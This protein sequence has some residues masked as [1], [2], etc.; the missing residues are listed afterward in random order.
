MNNSIYSDRIYSYQTVY[1]NFHSGENFTFSANMLTTNDL[2]L[3][4]GRYI[5]AHIYKPDSQN[6]FS[7]NEN[8]L[9]GKL[10]FDINK[11]D[12]QYV[13][14]NITFDSDYNCIYVVLISKGLNGTT[15]FD[16]VGLCKDAFYVANHQLITTLDSHNQTSYN[17]ELISEYCDEEITNT[18]QRPTNMSYESQVIQNADENSSTEFYIS[19]LVG[20]SYPNDQKHKYSCIYTYDRV[21]DLLTDN[22][23]KVG[24][25]FMI[26]YNIFNK[27]SLVIN[28]FN[29]NN[30]FC[31]RYITDEYGKLV[32]VSPIY[33]Y[34]STN[35]SLN[36][37]YLLSY[38]G[39]LLSNISAISENDGDDFVTFNN[40]E[41]SV[42]ALVDYEYNQWGD[43]KSI[44]CRDSSRNHYEY[45]YD[46]KRNLTKIKNPDNTELNFTYDRNNNLTL[47]SDN[48]RRSSINYNENHIETKYLYFDNNQRYA[49]CDLMNG[50][51]ITYQNGITKEYSIDDPSNINYSYGINENGESEEIINN[52][53]YTY[54]SLLDTNNSNKIINKYKFYDSENDL[55]VK[56]NISNTYDDFGRITKREY[57]YR[58]NSTPKFYIEYKYVNSESE[59]N[60]EDI[61]ANAVKPYN[62]LTELQIQDDSI[63]ESDLVEEVVYYA[64]RFTKL[65]SYKYSYDKNDN[66][67]LALETDYRHNDN[68][69]VISKTSYSY[70]DDNSLYSETDLLNYTT[71]KYYYDKYGN[72]IRK[73]ISPLI[74]L[75]SNESTLEELSYNNS[76]DNI[77]ELTSFELINN[78]DY[79]D[80]SIE[81][82]NN[83]GRGNVT[84]Y[85]NAAYQYSIN[86]SL[87]GFKANRSSNGIKIQNNIDGKP[88][89]KTDSNHNTY[90]YYWQDGHISAMTMNRSV[91]TIL[92]DNDKNPCGFAHSQEDGTTE[93]YFYILDGSNK[94]MGIMDSNLNI[95]TS[96]SYDA[97]GK[98]NTNF[99]TEIG[100]SVNALNPLVYNGYLYDYDMNLYFINGRYYSPKFY[101]YLT[102]DESIYKNCELPLSFNPYIYN[103]NN[104]VNS[105]NT[106]KVEQIILQ[107]S[108][109]YYKQKMFD[110]KPI[111]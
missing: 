56:A 95:I 63:I 71:Y 21:N 68:G 100:N 42:K 80:N 92:Y 73:T 70:N 44:S 2:P 109:E 104:P 54:K 30:S 20:N 79:E 14:N 28:A 31:R 12:W 93:V 35:N 40:E 74:S 38:T 77:G 98:L 9:L 46:N 10:H 105:S 64:D 36:N 11:N 8:Y 65:Y 16:G 6:S 3:S 55:S 91:V 29:Y 18:I 49:T 51:M 67:V 62:F 32:L 69:N 45:S 39:S 5:E 106:Y 78:N 59:L 37:S 110:Y 15:Y 25:I 50:H 90:K 99:S 60:S 43:I 88:Y 72:I 22:L 82:I 47:V 81:T 97:W 107:Q 96:Y 57:Y 7:F 27:P 1:G 86:N 94:I 4:E 108:Q 17:H 85:N 34:Y 66:I 13:A 53:R 101:R 83:D 19:D 75:P 61:S 76:I 41:I 58:N 111:L 48:L 26:K 23:D 33:N 24:N 84:G 52:T 87:T 102:K 89:L 103:G